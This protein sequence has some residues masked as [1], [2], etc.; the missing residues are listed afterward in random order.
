MKE[1][2]VY[3]GAGAIGKLATKYEDPSEIIF[4]DNDEK[5]VGGLVNG[6]KVIGFKQ[7]C[8][9]ILENNNIKI[10]ISAG[11]WEE[12]YYQ[13]L[14]AGI[15]EEIISIFWNGNIENISEIYE[16]NIYS[17]DGEEVFLR[18]F[19]QLKE[20]GFYVD[21]GAYNPIRF[22]NTYWAYKKGWRGINIEPNYEGYKKFEFMREH[23]IN[24]N[25]G[26]SD[27]ESK[28]CY[29][30]FKEG[31]LN[32]FNKEEIHDMEQVIGK[33]EVLVRRLDS[34]LEEHK[35]EKI[36][37]MD[38]DV[39]GLEIN[40]LKSNNWEKYRPTIILCEQKMCFEDILQSEVY[41]YLKS[42][43]YVAISKFNRTMIYKNQEV[44]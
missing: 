40:V 22:S 21:I 25:C 38:I 14:E 3:F 36:D 34:I 28:L 43:G 2:R 42:V 37:Y 6:I 19:F 39:E 7:L 20:N 1:K 10:I 13:C 18:E 32:T 33:K 31:A 15:K 29:Y 9:Y 24:I 44:F 30:M 17:Q 23:D 16:T 12:I 8:Q 5:K 35:V 27:V 11:N 41:K 4:C 26:V